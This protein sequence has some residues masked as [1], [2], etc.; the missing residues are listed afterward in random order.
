MK[1]ILICFIILSLMGMSYGCKPDSGKAMAY[2]CVSATAN[3]YHYNENCFG[4][5]KCTHCIDLV[6][7][8]Y[9]E[10]KGYTPCKICSGQTN[11][12]SK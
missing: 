10:K 6:T 5:N 7:K 12:R 8:R 3:K 11:L 2:I 1:K 9:A 4:L